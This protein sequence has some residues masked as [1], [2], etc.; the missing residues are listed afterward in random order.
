MEAERQRRASRDDL[1]GQQISR[2]HQYPP[3]YPWSH[4]PLTTPF[5]SHAPHALAGERRAGRRG[6]GFR[7]RHAAQRDRSGPASQ[8]F[9]THICRCAA[10]Q[11]LCTMLH[12]CRDVCLGIL[13]LVRVRVRAR[14]RA[15]ARA[16]VGVQNPHKSVSQLVSEISL[17]LSLSP[18]LR[19]RWVVT[20]GNYLCS[21]T[22]TQTQYSDPVVSS[23]EAA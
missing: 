11:C 23:G 13:H 10:S 12:H 5:E 20:Q 19:A 9:R 7:V 8:T 18:F 3:R 16:R 15:R 1:P 17:S 4:L 21:F 2:A 22:T 6:Q 14:V